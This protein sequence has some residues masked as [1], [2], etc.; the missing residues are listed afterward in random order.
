[1]NRF[2]EYAA[3]H[4]FLIAATAL[5]ALIAIALEVRQR[6]RGSTAIGTGD[7]VQLANQGALLLD[8]RG[9]EEFASGHII[10]AKHIRG[11]DLAASAD[12][13]KKYREKPIVVYCE[14]GAM[15]ATAARVLK[16]KGFAKVASIKG[17]LQAWRQDNLPLVKEN[18][19]KAGKGLKGA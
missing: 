16:A 18:K 1:M 14:S 5:L 8:V 7:A 17:G 4:P 19:G 11:S 2:F 9:D 3:N 6:V 12:T 10:D 15:S 13:L